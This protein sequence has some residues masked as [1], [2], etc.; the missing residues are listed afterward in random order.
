MYRLL[1]EG[2]LDSTKDFHNCN[3]A[4]NR[5]LE[6]GEYT[7]EN[8]DD[9]CFD[10]NRRRTLCPRQ[11]S[12]I[13][14]WLRQIIEDE[15]YQRRLWQDQ[16]E[17]VECWLEKDTVSFLVQNMT[18]RWGV[19]LRIS[20]GH[21]SRT[22]LRKIAESIS[23]SGT[24]V[25]LRVFY[26]GDFDPSGLD[27]ERAAR[28]GSDGRDGV[29]DF[30]EKDFGWEPGRFERQVTWVRL[31]VTE[32]D[33]RMMPAKARVSLKEDGNNGKKRRGDPRAE[34]F[35]EKYGDYG[36]EVEALEV[37]EPGGLERRVEEVIREHI[38][39]DAWKA[40]EQ[41]MKQEWKKYCRHMES[42]RA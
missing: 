5:A 36:V 30:L 28:R 41:K 23:I 20:S 1:S 13:K 24:S 33:Y 16:P 8:F 22:F 6:T 15:D 39:F 19:P 25:P 9:D 32:E 27:V 37:L 12:N 11:W 7:D 14:C 42:F 34:A 10:D 26:I 3:R 38:D 17:R 31:G 4:I 21:Y 2:L 18:W 35:K 40:S 29:A